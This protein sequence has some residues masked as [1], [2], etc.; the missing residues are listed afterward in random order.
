MT[1]Y[2]ALIIAT[3]LLIAGC[4]SKRDAIDSTPTL[5][6]ATSTS[7]HHAPAHHAT[8]HAAPKPKSTA[9]A[10]AH[11]CQED[12]S[13]WDCATM[14]NHICGGSRPTAPAQC[15]PASCGMAT[16]SHDPSSDPG[17]IID[18][19]NACASFADNGVASICRSNLRAGAVWVFIG[20]MD[21]GHTEC[22]ELKGNT[23]IHSCNEGYSLS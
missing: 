6:P 12:E 13:C 15:T 3:A 17:D 19:T 4:N 20:R 7:A 22:W 21:S 23:T 5:T 18:Q 2:L 16:M 10:V 9:P 1:K 14:G 11:D 8:H